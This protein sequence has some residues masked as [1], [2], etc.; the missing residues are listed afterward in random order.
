MAEPKILLMWINIWKDNS[1]LP[2]T[3]ELIKEEKQAYEA[4]RSLLIDRRDVTEIIRRIESEPL[5]TGEPTES[6]QI[7]RLQVCDEIRQAAPGE[8]AEGGKGE[9]EMIFNYLV[10]GDL[11]TRAGE[12]RAVLLKLRG[13][14]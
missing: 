9:G 13:K 14:C 5:A 4:L 7:G 2:A 11:P 3:E 1:P 10:T 8:S 12:V 6:V